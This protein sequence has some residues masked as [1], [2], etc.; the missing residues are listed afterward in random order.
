MTRSWQACRALRARI[1]C[2]R[3]LVPLSLV[4]A[5]VAL[6]LVPATARATP[7]AAGGAL[8]VYAGEGDPTPVGD[9]TTA[10]GAQPRYAMDFLFGNTW[11]TITQARQPYAKWKGT[12]YT[13]IWGVDMLPDTYT[14]NDNVGVPG[15]SCFGLTLGAAG[16]F[17]RYFQT[18]GR[19]IVRNGFASSV[20]RVGWEFNGN[21]FPWAAGGCPAAYVKYFDHIVTAMRS[22][23]GEHFTFEWNPTRGDLGVGD[24]AG[25]YP[26]DAYVG[27]VGLDVY[28]VEQHSYPGAR[29][30]FRHMETEIDGLNWLVSFAAAHHKSIV[31]PEW[32]LGWGTC[33]A[34]GQSVSPTS[35]DTCGGDDATWVNLMAAWIASHHVAEAT[36]WD[37]RTSSVDGQNRLVAAALRKD[38]ATSP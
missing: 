20:I 7:P 24:L 16:E 17:D 38:F 10:V 32:G 21:W 31:L 5:C 15:G 12:G 33:S 4:S 36:Y 27:S 18:V 29:A 19:N 8:G 3:A 9:F 30:E 34:R 26:G 35:G 37:F 28:D 2:C 11:R 25:Y 23:P 6:L 1:T 14:P 13:M 22:V